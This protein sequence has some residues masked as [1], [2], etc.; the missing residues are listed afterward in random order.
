MK[1][2]KPAIEEAKQELQT[3]MSDIGVLTARRK[4]L[5][6]FIAS[7]E[8]LTAKGI[9]SEAHAEAALRNRAQA[10][11]TQLPLVGGANGN[12]HQREMWENVAEAI[13][14][15]GRP[16]TAGEIVAA[17]HQMGTPVG[18]NFQRENVRATLNRKKDVFERVEAGLF[19]L[20]SWPPDR[21]TVK[22]AEAI[23]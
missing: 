12:G 6:A 19:A 8:M 2:I 15:A 20:K 10:P 14:Q 21:K 23:Q 18:G 3:V 1:T 17:M 4:I 9:R 5:E 13:N 22:Q 16:M 7:G 11:M